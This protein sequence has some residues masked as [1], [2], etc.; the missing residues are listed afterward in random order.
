MFRTEPRSRCRFLPRQATHCCKP[1]WA[2]QGHN[3]TGKD[4]E[5]HIGQERCARVRNNGTRGIIFSHLDR[6]GGG[7]TVTLLVNDRKQFNSTPRVFYVF[8]LKALSTCFLFDRRKLIGLK[9]RFW[10][11]YV[12]D[13]ICNQCSCT[14]VSIPN[15]VHRLRITLPDAQ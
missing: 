4:G 12:D 5:S 8:V 2:Y 13:R 3:I 11:E 6:T 7:A 10:F 15:P 9:T 14:G 1:L